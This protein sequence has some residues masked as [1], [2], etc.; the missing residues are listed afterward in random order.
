MA[1]HRDFPPRLMPAPQAAHYLGCSVTKLR[2]L[3]ITRRELGGKRV[4]DKADLDAY[5][6][7][8]PYEGIEEESENTC[9]APFPVAR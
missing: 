8:L 2:D 7:S 5:A 4:Y 3:P 6:D 1:L 9:D